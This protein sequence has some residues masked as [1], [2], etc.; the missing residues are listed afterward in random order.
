MKHIPKL[1]VF[2]LLIIRMILETT[3]IFYISLHVVFIKKAFQL[4]REKKSSKKN[5]VSHCL[6]DGGV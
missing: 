6:N 3:K 5:L 1:K 4:P 2:I